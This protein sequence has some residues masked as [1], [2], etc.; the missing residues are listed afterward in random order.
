M[1]QPQKWNQLIGNPTH[2]MTQHS[3]QHVSCHDRPKI[4]CTDTGS[5]YQQQNVS[6]KLSY[7]YVNYYPCHEPPPLT[8]T[9]L[10][11]LTHDNDALETVLLPESFT[12]HIAVF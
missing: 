5:I 6:Y 1:D 4:K 2:T 7:L 11:C 12:P 9:Y 3:H 10:T 8:T